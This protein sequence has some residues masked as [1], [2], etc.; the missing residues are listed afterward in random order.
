MFSS[1]KCVG[2]Y[3]QMYKY[4][5]FLCTHR[6]SWKQARKGS[7]NNLIW[8]FYYILSGMVPLPACIFINVSLLQ[9]LRS[10]NIA[11]ILI[12][13]FC[14]CSKHL[15]LFNP[16][17]IPLH[18]PKAETGDLWKRLITGSSSNQEMTVTASSFSLGNGFQQT[19]GTGEQRGTAT[20]FR[21]TSLCS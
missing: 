12:I 11:Q 16:R 9:W 17:P 7:T 5:P 18:P 15:F 13:F 14:L 8:D 19:R 20:V 3:L 1:G 2:S 10:E 6:H 4:L 21:D